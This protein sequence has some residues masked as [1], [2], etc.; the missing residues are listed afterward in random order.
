[1]VVSFERNG[2]DSIDGAM[3]KFQS[4][5]DFGG[6]A[7][8]SIAW[9]T[10]CGCLKFTGGEGTGGIETPEIA[11]KSGFDHLIVS[12]NAQ[13]PEGSCLTIYAQGR[14]DGQ[15]TKWYTMGI[16]NRGGWPQ[17]RTSV[18]G[19]DDD[20]GTVDCDV[21]KLKKLADAFKV[22]V[23]F[24]SA[25]GKSY[26]C[27]RFLAMNVIDSSLA[28]V[29]APPVKQVWGTE[30]DVPY[31]CQISEEG[32][33][34]WCSPTSTS[35]L[36]CYWSKK[37]NRPELRTTVTQTARGVH[38]ESWG[39]T[40]NWIFNTAHASE[41]PGIRGYVTRFV[42]VSQI[43]Q[44]IGKG[45]PVIVSLHSSRLRREDSDTDPGHLMVIRGFTADG[46]P[47]FNDPWPRGGKAED[48]PKEFPVEDLRKVF[49]REDL[50]YAW[51]GPQGSWGTVYL[52]YP[53]AMNPVG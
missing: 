23:E 35:M 41:F 46:D 43:E 5:E 20:H 4:A 11:V 39:G 18:K 50:E 49:K 31:L 29:D 28:G 27:L 2:A 13:T 44:W 51:L 34:G 16:W 9:D 33:R 19:Q 17:A 32:G 3:I 38:D 26:P 7:M 25:D 1:M 8:D 30:L 36:L 48:C 42:S 6:F 53:E 21:M 52:I 40:G 45:F 14:I 12:W 47:I 10:Q 24:S 37:L 22:K 15:W